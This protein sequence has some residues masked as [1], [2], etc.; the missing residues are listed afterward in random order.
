V[1]EQRLE[2]LC[3]TTGILT[4][5]GVLHVLGNSHMFNFYDDNH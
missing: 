5:T 3:Q 2:N 1:D 4:T